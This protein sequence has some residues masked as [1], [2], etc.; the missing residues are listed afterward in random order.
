[1][2]KPG[3]RPYVGSVKMIEPS[4]ATITSFGL[5]RY[6]AAASGT[7]A[8]RGPVG[9]SRTTE[10][11][12]CSQTI[13]LPSLSSVM[14]LHL[15]L[16]SSRTVTPS[17]GCQRRRLSPG[18]S[19]KCSDPSGIQIG[20]SVKVNPVAI[21]STSAFSSTSSRSFSDCTAIA[22]WA[23]SFVVDWFR[24]KLTLP[25]RADR[26]FCRERRYDATPARAARA[27]AR[28]AARNGRAE[29]RCPGSLRL[30]HGRPDHGDD[31]VPA[32][33]QDDPPRAH[34]IGSGRRSR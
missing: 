24:A 29:H 6:L 17:S 26:R 12:T 4:D 18:M 25:S 8:S 21:R 9:R 10:L 15:R 7:R 23:A 16:G 3:I 27:G 13:R 31:V 5:F 32:L 34:V 22:I 11:V 1:M 19:L 2:P 20:P 33:R 28:G 30:L 14:P